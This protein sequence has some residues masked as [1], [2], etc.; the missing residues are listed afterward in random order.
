MEPPR[1]MSI[2]KYPSPV[3]LRDLQFL[4][5]EVMFSAHTSCRPL[6]LETALNYW[7]YGE[8]D[9][10][11]ITGLHEDIQQQKLQRSM[12][13]ALYPLFI[14]RSLKYR[15]TSSPHCP[16]EQCFVYPSAMIPERSC[17]RYRT[18]IFRPL[19]VFQVLLLESS[20]LSLICLAPL[21]RFT[22]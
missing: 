4:N 7:G 21:V 8:S 22:R 5:K 9:S 15:N 3:L 2:Q 17:V 18:Y 14:P 1:E 19:T 11:S 6:S 10:E 12:S 20:H 13:I 16:A